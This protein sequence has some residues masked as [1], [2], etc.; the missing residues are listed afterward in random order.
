M[1]SNIKE[2][3]EIFPLGTYYAYYNQMRKLG[4]TIYVTTEYPWPCQDADEIIYL[5]DKEHMKDPEYQKVFFNRLKYGNI[6]DAVG[7]GILYEPPIE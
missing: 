7:T 5:G 2:L 1:E 4:K 6:L 3:K